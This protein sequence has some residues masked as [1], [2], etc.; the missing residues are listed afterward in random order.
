MKRDYE[1]E[2]N[3]MSTQME[4]NGEEWEKEKQALKEEY[5][6]LQTDSERQKQVNKCNNNCM[7]TFSTFIVMY[8]CINLLF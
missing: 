5:Q 2:I 6:T 3:R 4:R 8:Q 1:A 7:H